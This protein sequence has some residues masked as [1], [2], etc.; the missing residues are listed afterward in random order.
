MRSKKSVQ[1]FTLIETIVALTLVGS[2][3]LPTCLWLYQSKTSHAALDRFRAAQFL[4]I[5]LNRAIILR[6]NKDW[7]EEIS[8]PGYLRLE[9]KVGNDGHEIRLMST[10]K[11]R[12]GRVLAQLQGAYFTGKP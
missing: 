1:G 10:A 8:E 2:V 7:S 4:E 5:K 12:Q 3:L 6:Q 11:D 9:I